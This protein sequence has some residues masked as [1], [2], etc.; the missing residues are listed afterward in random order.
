[1]TL[2]TSTSKVVYTGNGTTGPFAFSFPIFTS[3]DLVVQKYTIATGA[4]ETLVLTTDY[5]VSGA[6]SPTNPAPGSVTL[7]ASLSSS[8]KLIITKSLSYTQETDLQENDPL[9]ANTIEFAIDR[10]VMLTQ[11][12]KEVIDRSVVA[13]ASNTSGY[14]LPIPTALNYL[15][16][17]AGGTGIENG[18]PTVTSTDYSGT[19]SSGVAAS[20]PA[21]P[22]AND[23]YVE[24][25]TQKIY[26]CWSGGTWSEY[27]QLSSASVTAAKLAAQVVNA[28][29]TVT[30][31]SSDYIMLADA[32]DSGNV[33][34]ALAS[35]FITVAASQAEMET[36]SSTSVFTP[37]GRVHYH[38]GVAKAWIRFNGTGTPAVTSSY[39]FDS[40]ITDNGTGDYTVSITNDFS[41]A[42]WAYAFGATQSGET[43][44]I[45]SQTTTAAGTKRIVCCN[46]GGANIDCSEI[47]LV[48]FGDQ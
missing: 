12:L 37:P 24:T 13:D 48:A 34:K 8:Y 15:R 41:N 11:Q 47:C 39:N 7:T 30:G 28:L 27:V 45:Y 17:N 20:K 42:N 26:V 5:S 10:S 9:P 18:N 19:I 44:Y 46:S 43:A 23:I 6:F 40:S 35:D 2:S 29:T 31:V 1:M 38:P 32:S 33:K 3:S 22:S 21:S 25:D 14:T 16:W 4:I 36:A